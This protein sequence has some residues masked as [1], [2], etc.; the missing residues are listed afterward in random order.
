MAGGENEVKTQN[1]VDINYHYNANAI[2]LGERQSQ[3]SARN[4]VS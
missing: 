3:V 2:A 1:W 4:L